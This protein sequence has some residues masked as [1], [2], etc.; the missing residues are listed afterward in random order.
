MHDQELKYKQ[1][2]AKKEAH[3]CRPQ[4]NQSKI[5]GKGKARF[6]EKLVRVRG[7]QD[8]IDEQTQN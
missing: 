7:G 5:R 4:I 6:G 8:S 3:K 2:L 1:Y